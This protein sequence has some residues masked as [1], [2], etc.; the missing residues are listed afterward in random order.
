MQNEAPPGATSSV[1]PFQWSARIAWRAPSA[2]GGARLGAS[3]VYVRRH[4]FEVTRPVEFDASAP[5][6]SALECVLG[7]F[8]ADLVGG[9]AAVLDERRIDLEAAEAAIRAELDNPLVNLGVIG[10]PRT[11][12]IRRIEAVVYVTSPG[13]AEELGAAW[14]ETLRRSPL[15]AT[16]RDAVTLELQLRPVA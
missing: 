11:P 16:L 12:R 9:L 10:E 14:D 7:A 2:T 3:A 13:G 1:K 15:V 8:G 6:I 5:G 4:A